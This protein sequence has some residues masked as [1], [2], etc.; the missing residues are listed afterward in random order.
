MLGDPKILISPLILFHDPPEPV[1]FTFITTRGN[2]ILA[3]I[4]NVTKLTNLIGV[5]LSGFGK[6]LF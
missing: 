5:Q 3:D 6:H 4:L 2:I 1:D